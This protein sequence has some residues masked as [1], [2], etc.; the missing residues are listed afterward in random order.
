MDISLQVFLICLALGGVVGFLAG[1]LG[2]GGG[3]IIVP[4]LIVLFPYAGINDDVLMPMVLATSLAAILLTA[5]STLLTHHRNGNIPHFF[6]PQ[7]LVGVAVGGL[8]GGYF[9]DFIASEYLKLFF[10]VFAILMSIQMWF[11]SKQ[12]DGCKDSIPSYPPIKLF[13]VSCLIG[14]IASLLGI[15]GGVLLV[16]FLTSVVKLDL[17]RAIGA[18]A[19]V[20]FVVAA[21]GTIGYLAAGLSTVVSLPSWSVGYVY[22]PALFGIICVSL[23][24]APVGVNIAQ[25][26]PV[27]VLKR[28]FSLLLFIVAVEILIN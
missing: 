15:G 8:A 26:L 6:L 25:R 2:I 13:L 3:L 18:S 12:A 5:I 11:G 4:V 23:F 20:G 21:M 10:A 14:A 7:L 22:F 17:R 28:C 1:L 9:A 24:T 16:P 27:K 19:A